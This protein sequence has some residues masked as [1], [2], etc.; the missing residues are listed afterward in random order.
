M[1]YP[2][3]QRLDLITCDNPWCGMWGINHT[4]PIDLYREC[5]ADKTREDIDAKK[6]EVLREREVNG[7]K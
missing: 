3:A 4:H 2:N 1:T 7:A 5:L 6:A